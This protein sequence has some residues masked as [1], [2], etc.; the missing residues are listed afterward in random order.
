M[1][2]QGSSKIMRRLLGRPQSDSTTND[3]SNLGPTSS[4]LPTSY[5]PNQSQNV[6]YQASQPIVCLDRSADGRLAVLGGRDILKTIHID[7]L[8]V[9]EGVDLRAYIQ[10]QQANRSSSLGNQ[11]AIKDV[12]WSSNHEGEP[13][14][15]T[16]CA[17]GQ[18][19]QYNVSRLGSATPGGTVLDVIQT[20]EESRQIN[21]LDS[22]PHKSSLLLSGG[23][24]G[25][26]R[27]FDVR[28]PQ[29]TRS[30]QLTFHAF[31]AFQG[32]S[33]G[34]RD[35]KWCP[36]D[37][38]IFAC[39]TDS[40][41]ILK[42]DVKKAN[43][44]L[45]K[46][47]AHASPRG[48]SSISWHPD[49]NHLISGGFDRKCHVWDMSTTAERRQKPQWTIS[50]PAP[51]SVVSWR[52]PLWSAT[53]QGKRA[54]QVAVS[55]GDSGHGKKYGISGV[56]IWDLGRP[57]MPYKE[58]DRF[59]ISPSALL[60][61]D[62]DLLWTAGVDGIF[63]QSDV[64]F[65][66]KT[67]D[68]QP[69]SS[70]DFS[71]SGDVVMMLEERAHPPRPRPTTAVPEVP[72]SF[73]TSPSGQMLSVSRSDSEDDVVGSFLGPRKRGGRRRRPSVRSA[74][75][76]NTTPPSGT[77]TEEPI[78]SLEQA[79]NLTGTFKPQQIMAIGRVPVASKT[80]IYQYLASHYLEALE[81]GLPVDEDERPLNER[82][83]GI[84]DHYARAA[85][86]VSQFRLAQTWRIMA[87]AVDLLLTR[88]SEYHLEMRTARR[89][90]SKPNGLLEKSDSK[91]NLSKFGVM[92]Q[93]KVNGE[94]SP[95]R[96]TSVSSM[97]SRQTTKKSLLAEEID[98]ESNAATPLARPVEDNLPEDHHQYRSSGQTLTP[99]QEVESFT[100]PPNLNANLI[101]AAQAEALAGGRKRLDSTPISED[102]H[103]SQISSTEGYDFYDLEAVDVLPKAIDMPK[104][105]EPLS[106]DYAGPK[107][108]GGS[109]QRMTVARHD[110]DESFAQIFS[111]SDTSH[112]TSV[113]NS[114]YSRMPPPASKGQQAEPKSNSGS[115][116]TPEEEYE[117]RIRGRQL[118]ALP[119]QKK[120]SVPR[121]PV[122]QDSSDLGEIFM[123]S[124][125]T[126]D[127]LESD[128]S[129]HISHETSQHPIEHP[130]PRLEVMRSMS[131]RKTSNERVALGRPEEQ[132]SKTVIET[133]FMPWLD[134]PDFPF[135]LLSDT[136]AKTR[137]VLP[138]LDPYKLLSRALEF[139][140]QHS[141][142]N[143]SAMILLLKPLVPD[144]VI[145]TGQATAI[146]THHHQRL[147]SQKLFVEAALLRNLC[148]RDW[149]DGIDVWGDNYTSIFNRAQQRVNVGFT[150]SQ[151]HKPREIDRSS[152]SSNG[153]PNAAA[154]WKCERCRATMAPCAI[155]GHRDATASA[156]TPLPVAEA[157][158][159]T[160][161]A[162]DDSVL[163]TW[164]YCPGCAHGGH[165][166]C[167]Q[168]WHAPVTPPS[169]PP[170][171]SSGRQRAGTT[172]GTSTPGGGGNSNYN[173]MSLLQSHDTA[174]PE[175]YSD[176][177]CPL[178]GCG[179]ACLPGKWRNETNIGKA[180]ELGRA[181]REQTRAGT[182]L[183]SASASVSAAALQ[184]QQQQQETPSSTSSSRRHSTAAANPIAFEPYAGSAPAVV[185]GV[186]SD[187]VEVSQSRAV[188]GVREAL[189]LAGIGRVGTG[190][191]GG[192][193]SG[194]NEPDRLSSGY[195]TQNRSAGGG[196]MSVL[197]S[198]PGRVTSHLATAFNTSANNTSHNTESAPA[199]AYGG[200]GSGF[201]AG[202]GA[203]NS[204]SGSGGTKSDRTD[205]ERRKS[206]KFGGVTE[207]GRG[208]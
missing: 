204:G 66:P 53:A 156:M 132:T 75:V 148:V 79:I 47:N 167:I 43:A 168:G 177:C 203:G 131:P 26:V 189:A 96:A 157:L 160:D 122:R 184:R 176:G 59:E 159:R 163:A 208:R 99:V 183:A 199:T 136:N 114:S 173:F 178:D 166:T 145:D 15:F 64:A 10:A 49:G 30:G 90:N 14:I 89:K 125:T 50:A 12:K 27:L 78:I 72:S 19:F 123:I 101:N 113:S 201:G 180:E 169:T 134:D 110:S 158:A 39:A 187:I 174:V 172:S 175:T 126:A 144:E 86:T 149:P 61:H 5:R 205:R 45:L 138:P 36:K 41:A 17:S 151:C 82:V 118:D 21:K 3:N 207:D 120:Q 6:V 139:E 104:K 143:A 111:V 13:T 106:L 25:I 80:A 109:K 16:A 42:W 107:T 112:D 81:K 147:M 44:P 4:P 185:G 83:A 146:L 137:A 51:V 69:L 88:R 18:I 196:I 179:H 1:Y 190:G 124:Q 29:P 24:E 85:E 54:A 73:S 2:N 117:S 34:I 165:A 37:G 20:Q 191:S 102:S 155:C 171:N 92:P 93:L 55:Y 9:R 154:I 193:G 23:Q 192:S 22:N 40:G 98:S 87:Y 128:Y 62:Q 127:S 11:L 181:V 84:M 8:H 60:W 77:G 97:E 170:P 74:Q 161:D 198:S 206:V 186:R 91:A 67:M 105:R 68:R 58:I 116:S 188:E 108:P 141:A 100:L 70:V 65:A 33:E 194:E 140:A 56:H 133:D 202:G 52:P 135:P 152:G 76:Y 129:P 142:L 182:P 31:K 200:L 71:P 57:T 94:A 35:I 28:S 48:T 103:D 7:G 195:H 32:N 121:A 119:D 95:R 153:E 115:R 130:A 162:E 164:W 63:S 46:I 197:S 38:F 150:C